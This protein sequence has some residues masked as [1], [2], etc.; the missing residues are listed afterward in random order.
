MSGGFPIGLQYGPVPSLKRSELLKPFL[1][2]PDDGYSACFLVG[3]EAH[4]RGP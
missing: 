1:K 4:T 2:V 3:V